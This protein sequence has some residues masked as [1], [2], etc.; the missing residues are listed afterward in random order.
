MLRT[1]AWRNVWRNGRRS[2]ILIGAVAFGIWSGLLEMA[3][4]NGVARQQE[5]AAIRTR[6]S[7]L[8][9]H[10][11]GFLEHRE[12]GRVVPAGD[13]VLA[14]VRRTPRVAAASGRVVMAV[15]ASS[16]TTARG[17]LG[18]GVDPAAERQVTDVADQIVEGSYFGGAYR[19]AAVIG[20][21]LA[22]R[23]GIRLGHKLVLTGQG[24]DGAIGVGAF[25]VVGLYET[26]SSGFDETAVFTRRADLARTFALGDGLHEIAVRVGEPDAIAPV[27]AALRR[28]HPSLDVA[29]WRQIAPEVALTR[30]SNQETN[31]IFLVIILVALVFGITNTMLMG[32]MERTRELGVLIALGMRPGAL[33]GM[34]ILETVLVSA[35]GGA[36]GMLLAAVSVALLA[37]T[38][39]DLSFVS[40]GLAAFGLERVVHPFL[41]AGQYPWVVV[42]VVAT[43]LVASLY[44][45]WRAVRL[46]PVRAIQSYP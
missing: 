23:L 1:I 19:N 45:G 25:R 21:R 39:V 16:A 34:V 12:V 33:F 35:V 9:I 46:D 8:Q 11:R 20:R 15:M 6:T 13:S 26:A 29:T 43:A 24:A 18:Y 41:P 30:D 22:N 10:A 17:V 3:F 28:A 38:G 4:M 31:E 40:S 42:L 5:E 44:P 37:H 32:V 14:S 7:H 2:G 36:A 27:A